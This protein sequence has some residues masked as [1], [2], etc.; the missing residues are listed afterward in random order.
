MG[1]GDSV[2][3]SYKKP[4]VRDTVYRLLTTVMDRGL[5]SSEVEEFTE[6]HHGTVS[7]ALSDLHRR[8]D[9]ARLTEKR[10]GYKVYV[11]PQ[12]VNGRTVEEQGVD[13]TCPHCGGRL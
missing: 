5:T 4:E 10:S 13:R 3:Q 11:H 7:G 1:S 8:G 9:I 2:T 6:W 12:Y